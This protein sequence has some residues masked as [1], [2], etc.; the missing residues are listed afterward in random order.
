MCSV[1]LILEIYCCKP[2]MANNISL[3]KNNELYSHLFPLFLD[4]GLTAF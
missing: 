4:V 2:A 1:K 3:L